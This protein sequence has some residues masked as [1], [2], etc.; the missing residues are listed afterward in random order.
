M[1][2]QLLN[3]HQITEL[4]R[5]MEENEIQ[6]EESFQNEGTYIIDSAATPTHI[7]HRTLFKLPLSKPIITLTATDCNNDATHIANLKLATTEGTTINLPVL[8]NP[9]MRHKLL[10]AHDIAQRVG[11]ILLTEKNAILLEKP[12]SMHRPHSAT[13]KKGVHTKR[14]ICSNYISNTTTIPTQHFRR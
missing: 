10:S 11:T 6:H 2:E 4:A 3:M 7:K 13:D 1:N 12:I 5:Q 14:R 9:T 8:Y